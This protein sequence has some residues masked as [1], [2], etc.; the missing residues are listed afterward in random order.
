[1]L[2]GLSYI[3]GLAVGWIDAVNWLE[4]FAVFTSY[5][6][7]WLCVRQRR[8]NYPIG[9]ASTAAYALLFWQADLMSSFALNLYLTPWL[10]YGWIRW[11]RDED[12]RPVRHVEWKMLPLYALFT[13]A[14]WSVAVAIGNHYGA[15]LAW[16]DSAILALTLLA[17]TL[18]DNKIEETWYAWAVVNVL[19]IYVYAT[20]GLPLVALQYVM[21]LLNCFVGMRAWKRSKSQPERQSLPDPLT[22]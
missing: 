2:T 22:T 9:A 5:S 21:F 14:A 7:T 4:V 17:Q 8:I 13:G 15:A 16:T 1:M 6:C 11:R 20:S 10:I 19:A 18:L 12:T 3:V